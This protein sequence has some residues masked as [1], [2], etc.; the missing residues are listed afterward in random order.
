MSIVKFECPACSQNMECERACSG[1]VIHCP[2]CCAQIRIPFYH[3][4]EMEGSIARA[5]LVA[6]APSAAAATHHEGSPTQTS[7]PHDASA[8]IDCPACH[9][10]LKVTI[11]AE[12]APTTALLRKPPASAPPAPAQAEEA[13]P[14]FAHMSLEER[15]RQI[16][17]AREAHP[18][19]L[20]S[21]MKPRLEY[22]LSDK[23][24]PVTGKPKEEQKGGQKGKGDDSS[25]TVTE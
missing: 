3:G 6:P 16:A 11:P 18:V 2:R 15:E 17:A 1:D 7:K 10:E 9:A 21:T 13:H 14:D 4:T 5:E 25:K 24:A 23:A 8:K 19:Q 12:G 22:I 20:H